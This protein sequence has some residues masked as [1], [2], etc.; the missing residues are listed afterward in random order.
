M[1]SEYQ[2]R[3]QVM[4]VALEAEGMR[5]AGQS[6]FGGTSFWIEGP[7]GTD[8]DLLS[9]ELRSDG[10]L[11]E[12]GSPFFAGDEQ[13]CRYFRMAYSS[14]PANRIQEGVRLTQRKMHALI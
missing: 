13:P 9:R 5:I 6:N 3:H 7:E 10:V 8:A 2:K 14:I 12:S 1:R 11:I 4:A